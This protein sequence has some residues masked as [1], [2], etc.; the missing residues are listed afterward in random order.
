M[1]ELK[2][3]PAW[4]CARSF[5]ELCSPR[6][7]GVLNAADIELARTAGLKVFVY[8]DV[9]PRFHRDLFRSGRPSEVRSGKVCDFMREPCTPPDPDELLGPVKKRGDAK[10]QYSTPLNE[11]LTGAKH[12]ADVPLLTKLLALGAHP[13]VYTSEP[14]EADLFV[15]PF[16]GGFIERVSPQMT[17]AL[18]KDHSLGRGIMDALFEHLP[19]MTNATAARHI[20][21]LTNSCGC[22]P[23]CAGRPGRQPQSHL[24]HSRPRACTS[25]SSRPSLPIAC[26]APHIGAS[27]V[28]PAS[29]SRVSLRGTAAACARPVP[30]ALPGSASSPR[31]AQTSSWRT[32]AHDQF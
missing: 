26:A 25:A 2:L 15:V 3:S 24:E 30:T 1:E 14:R 12:C 11:W 8:R 29:C 6:G 28:R 21:L 13:D 4:P 17:N 19:H 22:A 16:L 27:A 20:F 32:R 7:L 23:A 31:E 10:P 9:P 5:G 18:R